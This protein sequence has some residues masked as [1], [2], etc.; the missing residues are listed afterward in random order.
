S[1]GDTDYESPP[2]PDAMGWSFSAPMQ[3]QLMVRA[4]RRFGQ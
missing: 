2:S 4:M 3:H 1:Q